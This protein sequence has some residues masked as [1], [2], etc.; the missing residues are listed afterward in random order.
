MQVTCSRERSGC[1]RCRKPGAKCTYSR[2]GVIRRSRKRK[3]E[4]T[5]SSQLNLEASIN[6]TSI[7][8]G[9]N[10]SGGGGGVQCHLAAD[11]EATR[12]RLSGLDTPEKHSS[13]DALSSLSEA[14]ASTGIWHEASKL[15]TAAKDFFLFEEHAIEWAEGRNLL[16]RALSKFLTAFPA[17]VF[18]NVLCKSGPLMSTAP[19]DV[20]DHL[21]AARPHQVRERAWLVMYYSIILNTVTSTSLKEKLQHNLWLA[22]SDVG[23]LFEPSEA[24]IH[25]MV[26]VLSQ[27]SEF[28]GPSL[29]WMLA[30]NACRMLQAL[31]V[32]QN[33]LDLQTRER[34]LVRFWHLNL[35]DKGLAIIFGRTPTFHRKMVRE[36]GLP[37]LEQIQPFR[38]H[39]TS[40]G[41]PGFFGAHYMYQKILLS[42]L[43]DDIWHCLYGEAK[44]NNHSIEAASKDLVS[45]YEQARR[46]RRTSTGN[47][48]LN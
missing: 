4:T 12:E 20:M 9:T 28:T 24:N 40:T 42:H 8:S 34:R 27:V 38:P 19:P 7:A 1:K 11:I 6:R 10:S 21:R 15:D 33:C 36:I 22:L 3:N 44:P 23:V 41:A 37:T 13:L 17:T 30:T 45:W 47:N 14:C 29:C 31:G 32:N 5:A 39:L 26:L 46:V 43:M 16:T 35:L 2:S 18:E 48:N 25:A